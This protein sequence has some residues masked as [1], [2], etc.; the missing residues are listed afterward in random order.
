MKIPIYS[1]MPVKPQAKQDLIKRIESQLDDVK[2]EIKRKSWDIKRLVAEQSI[3]KR[4]RKMFQDI[5]T[6]L[7]AQS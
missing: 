2:N 1:S 6:Q 4:E 3:L 7:K 5:I